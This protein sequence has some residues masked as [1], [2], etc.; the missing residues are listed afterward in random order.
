MSASDWVGLALTIAAFANV[1]V[2][3]WFGRKLE[4]LERELARSRK[5]LEDYRE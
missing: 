3:I 5:E 2:C 1:P 4:S